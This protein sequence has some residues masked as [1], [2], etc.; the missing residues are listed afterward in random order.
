[1]SS[2]S[3]NTSTARESLNAQETSASLAGASP[4]LETPARLW[5]APVLLAVICGLVLRIVLSLLTPIGGESVPG[6]LSSYNDEL[7]H[8]NYAMHI[9]QTHSLPG[10]VESIQRQGALARGYYENYQPPVYYLLLAGTASLISVRDL[11]GVV[12][13]ARFLGILFTLILGMLFWRICLAAKISGS[14]GASGVIFI[15]L[16]GVFVRFTSVVGNESLFWIFAG[17]MIL[18]SIRIVRDGLR[19]AHWMTF[20]ALGCLAI[21]TKFTAILLLP[22]P[23]LVLARGLNPR[24]AFSLAGMYG[25]ILVCVFPLGLRNYYEF[26]SVLPLNAGFGEPAW[27]IPNFAAALYAVRSFVF[28]WSEF[29]NGWL[30]LLFM[31]PY[32]LLGLWA[33]LHRNGWHSLQ[34]QPVL[35]AALVIAFA[36]FLWLN[37]RY[38]QAEGRYLFA[39]WPSIIVGL[40]GNS[41]SRMSLWLLLLF[42]LLPYSLMIIPVAG[43]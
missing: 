3:S 8:A 23:A 22:L 27:R 37:T 7:A 35:F 32:G 2:R 11:N 24:V 28:P 39:A 9:L 26:G 41:V 12:L 42:L 31:L 33:L 10:Q 16:S 18:I 40:S 29:W 25:L 1:M 19:P 14:L 38:N 4:D 13:L 36:S 20:A 6:M 17:A 30:G 34:S 21:Y 5:S 15:A 43:A